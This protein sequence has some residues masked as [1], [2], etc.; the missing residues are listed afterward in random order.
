M[1]IAIDS[2]QTF[3]LTGNAVT[4]NI[5]FNNAAG[6]LLVVGFACLRNVAGD[7]VSGITYNGVS[8]TKIAHRNG[9]ANN[10]TANMWYLLNPATGSNTLAI[11]LAASER[12]AGAVVSYTGHDTTTPI[13]VSNTDVSSGT[14]IV[15]NVT[16]VT[17]N[18]VLL[19]VNNENRGVSTLGT[20]TT[21][22]FN[23]AGNAQV[24][25]STNPIS[26]AGATTLSYTALSSDPGA[27]YVIAAIRPAA[28]APA[29]NSGWF[30]FL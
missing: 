15:M 9:T 26:P 3:G 20:N 5:T 2:T 10:R 30:H 4:H 22:V 6:G 27:P 11:T 28:G 21:S 16:T 23:S 1:A 17:D 19:G 25:R 12:V 7:S 13:D 18:A 24:L 8:L 14:S 29:A